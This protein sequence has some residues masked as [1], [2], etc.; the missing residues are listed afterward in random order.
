DAA[1]VSVNDG[2]GGTLRVQVNYPGGFKDAVNDKQ[3]DENVT[4]IGTE[5]Y[6][7][8]SGGTNTIWLVSKTEPPKDTAKAAKLPYSRTWKKRNGTSITGQFY[9]YSSG[10]LTVMNER[11]E[12]S[13]ARLSELTADGQKVV[14]LILAKQREY[15]VK[16]RLSRRR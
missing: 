1:H 16:T 2:R 6:N 9:E 8:V 3:F 13:K 5:R 15:E 10:T 11:R 12:M 14:R 4:V 7:T